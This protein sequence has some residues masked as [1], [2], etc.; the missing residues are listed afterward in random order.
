MIAVVSKRQTQQTEHTTDGQQQ[1]TQQSEQTTDGHQQKQTA[2]ISRYNRQWQRSRLRKQQ[3]AHTADRAHNRW[4][5]AE[6][7][8]SKHQQSKQETDTADRAHNRRQTAD[9]AHNRNKSVRA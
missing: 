6:A 2:S 4:P 3:E 9:R 1:K 5:T 8:S 7:N